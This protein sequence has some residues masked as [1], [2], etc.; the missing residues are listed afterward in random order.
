MA[1]DSTEVARAKIE[2]V[3][4]QFDVILHLIGQ[5]VIEWGELDDSLIHLLAI[6]SGCRLR[7]AGITYYALDAFSTRLAVIKGLAQHKLRK[8]KKR[9]KLLEF[10]ERLSKLGK[11]RNDIIHAIYRIIYDPKIEKMVD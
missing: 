9:T 1:V 4:Q 10:L 5:V 6:L 7:T 8:G 3:H 2:K 11:T